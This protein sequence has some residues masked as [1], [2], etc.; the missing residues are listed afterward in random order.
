MTNINR[1][2][3]WYAHLCNLGAMAFIP[4]AVY[5]LLT[6]LPDTPWEWEHGVDGDGNK[7]RI[8]QIY[9]PLVIGMLGG[10]G[11]LS[12]SFLFQIIEKALDD[13]RRYGRG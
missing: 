10:M 7:T 12:L 6:M 5:G 8:I 1:R 11:I 13:Y 2:L 9:H 3:L 4:V